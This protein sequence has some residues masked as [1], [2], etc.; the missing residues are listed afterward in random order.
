M[1]PMSGAGP[2]GAPLVN[3]LPVASPTPTPMP[4]RVPMTVSPAA[5]P[6]GANP[7]ALGRS[8][9]PTPDAGAAMVRGDMPMAFGRRVLP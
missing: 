1:R 7:G 5:V 8:F 3:G 2:V 4:N 6:G 9:N